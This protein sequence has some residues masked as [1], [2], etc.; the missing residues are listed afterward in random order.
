MKKIENINPAHFK[1]IL[2][3]NIQDN[4][5]LNIFLFYRSNIKNIKNNYNEEKSNFIESQE[6]KD[7]LNSLDLKN[8]IYRL[9]NIPNKINSNNCKYLNEL[10]WDIVKYNYDNFTEEEQEELKWLLYDLKNSNGNKI[11]DISISKDF[12]CNCNEMYVY[13]TDMNIKP[14]IM[15]ELKTYTLGFYENENKTI[16]YL[17]FINRE[18]YKN[19]KEFHKFVI[20][21]GKYIQYTM[22]KEEVIDHIQKAPSY[23][24]DYNYSFNTINAR[25]KK[26]KK[27]KYNSK[28]Y[29]EYVKS[30][31][32]CK[33]IECWKASNRLIKNYN[34]PQFNN[35]YYNLKELDKEVNRYIKAKIIDKSKIIYPRTCKNKV[36]LL[37]MNF[38]FPKS[39]KLKINNEI[40]NITLLSIIYNLDK[41]SY[42]DI[43][44]ELHSNIFKDNTKDNYDENIDNSKLFEYI[45]GK[46][47]LYMMED[48]NNINKNA[49]LETKDIFYDNKEIIKVKKYQ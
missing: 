5:V 49:I 19:Y 18:N 33:I 41:I 16:K 34:K 9:F 40:K 21:K 35:C 45:K 36:N 31:I 22:K 38:F 43:I 30:L 44:K 37:Y 13:F 27:L 1:Y 14:L 29:K 4:E 25:M 46:D 39:Q 20:S 28:E 10:Q 15:K 17:K 24:Y 8:M 48:S 12:T 6:F 3:P 11:N 26:T 2:L 32:H 47:I 23:F 7:F 42:T